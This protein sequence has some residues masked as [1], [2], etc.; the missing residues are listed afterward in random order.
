MRSFVDE[1]AGSNSYGLSQDA[2]EYFKCIEDGSALFE[3]RTAEVVVN[4]TE[5]EA[6]RLQGQE[7][8]PE[9]SEFIIDGMLIYDLSPL[10]GASA[11]ILRDTFGK[12]ILLKNVSQD[13]TLSYGL[14]EDISE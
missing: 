8:I 4:D 5:T 1:E 9:T 6:R 11:N 12:G 10:R 13:K 14:V 7:I 3:A 2:L